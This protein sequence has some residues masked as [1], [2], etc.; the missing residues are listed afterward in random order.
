MEEPNL[1]NILEERSEFVA[2]PPKTF[3]Q[4]R[5]EKTTPFVK[6]SSNES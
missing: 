6:G 2:E 1:H 3:E 4:Q 5:N